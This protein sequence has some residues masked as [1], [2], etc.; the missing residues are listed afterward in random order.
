MLSLPPPVSEIPAAEPMAM[1]LLP[2]ALRSACCPVAVL[3]APDMLAKS[4]LNP[5]AV[6]LTPLVLLRSARA[7]LAVGGVV[8]G[9]WSG[10]GAVVVGPGGLWSGWVAT[11]PSVGAAWVGPV[12]PCGRA[13]GPLL[14]GSGG[15]AGTT[16]C[17]CCGPPPCS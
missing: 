14:A 8:V 6:L 17:D 1:L 2:V 12:G 16:R 9:R 7:P 3:L 10:R 4:A 13:G 11:A 15:P 5:L